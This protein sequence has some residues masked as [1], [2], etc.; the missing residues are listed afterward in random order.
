MKGWLNGKLI[1]LDSGSH[2][3]IPGQI[4]AP[5]DLKEG[6]NEVLLKIPQG[7]G[8]WGF[9]FDLVD[10]DG[11]LLQGLVYSPRKN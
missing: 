11:K 2:G 6:W 4:E 5:V 9:Y 7:M 8:G 1:V 3:A 10:S